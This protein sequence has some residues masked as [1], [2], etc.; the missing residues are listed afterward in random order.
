MSNAAVAASAASMDRSQRRLAWGLLVS[1]LLHGLLLALH[2]GMPGLHAGAGAPLTVRLATSA[3]VP[4]PVQVLPPLP[5]VALPPPAAPQPVPLP[6][7]STSTV[8]P[9]PAMPATTAE[10]APSPAHHGFSL[11]DPVPAPVPA[12]PPSAPP[13]SAI[14][15][16]R[17]P[18]RSLRP[19]TPGDTLSARVIAQDMP[20]DNDFKLPPPAAGPKPEPD[21][22]AGAQAP[23][24]AVEAPPEVA[25]EPGP[26]QREEERER[27][28][29]RREREREARRPTDEQ[30]VLD[31]AETAARAEAE[32][33][34]E[35][36][37]RAA[38]TA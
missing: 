30:A 4:L 29:A 38:A 31:A 20:A 14:T 21:T 2:F 8:A 27:L 6:V 1:L 26:R 16:R 36:L 5:Q 22:M 12:P 24:A 37:A 23:D 25:S 34:S 11:L 9:L 17:S 3:P 19:R 28:A 10:M 13:A 35:V 15:P 33:R 18:R 32:H 7:P